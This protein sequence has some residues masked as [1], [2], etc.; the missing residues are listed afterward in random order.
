MMKV[1][2]NPIRYTPAL[3]TPIGVY[4]DSTGNRL[5]ATEFATSGTVKIFNGTTLALSNTLTGFNQPSYIAHDEVNNVFYVSEDVGGTSSSGRI[6]TINGSSLSVTTGVIT[7]LYTPRGIV[8]DNSGGRVIVCEGS[9]NLVKVYNL[10][11]KA[12]ITSF[13]CTGAT[14]IHW[15]SVLNKLYICAASSGE[16]RVF[17]ATTYQLIDTI[18]G[19]TG[20]Y[21]IT[22]DA[23]K[24]I[25]ANQTGNKISIINKSDHSVFATIAGISTPRMVDAKS[26]K[27]YLAQNGISRVSVIDA[28][29]V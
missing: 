16:V 28:P 22:G 26:G 5:L 2:Y 13:A 27:F 25:V 3:T 14:G 8:L 11:T 24:I 1:G 10:T 9:N 12:L 15:D 4:F 7:G 17:N 29:Y 19:L 20:P 6:S 18:A 21:G 23:N